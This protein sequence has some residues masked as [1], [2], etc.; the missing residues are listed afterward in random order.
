M[1]ACK[2]GHSFCDECLKGMFLMSDNEPVP[3]PACRILVK[4]ANIKPD[5]ELF[6]KINKEH[7]VKESL[8]E[9]DQ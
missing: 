8:P 1:N 3:C 4:K 5:H 6:R 7:K 9:E 2:N